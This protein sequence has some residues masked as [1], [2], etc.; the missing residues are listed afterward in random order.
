[1][2]GYSV[3]D[4]AGNLVR[5]LDFITGKSLHSHIGSLD[6]DHQTYF[7]TQFPGILNHFVE[8]IKAVGFLHEHG[9]KHGDI[10]RDHILIDRHSKRYRLIDFDYNYRHRENIY[11]Y[12]LFGIGNVLIFI[13]GR[14]DVRLPDLKN[15]DH[16][17]LDVLREEDMNI[18]FRY[19]VA[20]L[21]KI[22]PYI[23][24]TLNR[25]LMHFSKGANIFYENTAQIIDDLEEFI[26]P[27]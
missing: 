18:V 2:H 21:K 25:V 26:T 1:M 15:Q 10:R 27:I 24:E 14:G 23:P 12:D 22:Y 3:E 19:R 7:Y 5:V 13:V 16:P 9:E 20:N 4:Q 17:A 8:C 6:L 11:G